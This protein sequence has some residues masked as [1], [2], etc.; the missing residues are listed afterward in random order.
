MDGGLGL[1]LC[2]DGEGSSPDNLIRRTS[3][4]KPT[5]KTVSSPGIDFYDVISG[6][7]NSN[8]LGLPPIFDRSRTL[9]ESSDYN[10]SVSRR[11]RKQSES[12]IL[13]LVSRSPHSFSSSSANSHISGSHPH[14]RQSRTKSLSTT[15]QANNNSSKLG[16]LFE[17][18]FNELNRKPETGSITDRGTMPSKTSVLRTRSNPLESTATVGGKLASVKASS[19]ATNV[20]VNSKGFTKPPLKRINSDPKSNLERKNSKYSP[21]RQTVNNSS[22]KPSLGFNLEKRLSL[23]SNG[24]SKP[25]VRTPH[26]KRQ[27]PFNKQQRIER[28]K[29]NANDDL[30]ESESEEEFDERVLE[31]LEGV[32]EAEAPPEQEI[33]YEDTPPQSDN[34]IHIV[35]QDS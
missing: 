31:W 25:S 18:T 9:S 27:P 22:P 33:V 21:Q 7:M 23:D 13:D 10:S 11:A 26:T 5:L 8:K 3:Q 20:S 24:N 32:R 2:F 28:L 1:E 4:R 29:S 16:T 12:S 17:Q 15:D 14:T 30:S 34:A 6:N 19:R 35:Y